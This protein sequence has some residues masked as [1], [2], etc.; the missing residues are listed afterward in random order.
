MYTITVSQLQDL[1]ELFTYS[2]ISG[3]LTIV[4]WS[5]SQELKPIFAR[6]VKSQ[7]KNMIPLPENLQSKYKAIGGCTQ[8]SE[9]GDNISR[10]CSGMHPLVL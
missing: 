3:S 4:P 8:D 7:N 10:V 1:C 5:P 9:Y 6:V 2:I